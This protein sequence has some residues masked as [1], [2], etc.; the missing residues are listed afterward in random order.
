MEGTPRPPGPPAPDPSLPQSG[1]PP[2]ES[3]T[4]LRHTDHMMAFLRRQ[5]P[6]LRGKPAALRPRLPHIKP[7]LPPPQRPAPKARTVRVGSPPP[8]NMV[9][10]PD[11][12]QQLRQKKEQ[13]RIY[14]DLPEISGTD[15]PADQSDDDLPDLM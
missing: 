14:P 9:K 4:Q 8:P 5:K 10:D 11:H 3:A 2:G 6:A 15:A 7:H 1:A 12:Q 13:S